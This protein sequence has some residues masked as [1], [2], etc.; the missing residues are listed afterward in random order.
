[1]NWTQEF[2]HNLNWRTFAPLNL[3]QLESEDEVTATMKDAPWR[4]GIEHQVDWT[5][6]NAGVWTEEEGM[7]V[8]RLAVRAEGTLSWSFY[9]S[10]FVVPKGGELFV[11]NE[12]RTDYLGSFNHLN[13]KE[14]EGLALV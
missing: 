7:K 1:M 12:D 9:L 10:R 8:W 6:E 13:V 4:F 2:E 5:M 11:W 3:A 14:W